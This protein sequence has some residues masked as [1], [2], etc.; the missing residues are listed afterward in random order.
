MALVLDRIYDGVGFDDL[1]NEMLRDLVVSRACCPRS[2]LAT[3]DYLGRYR[4]REV[5]INV[6]YR[7]MDK[8]DKTYQHQRVQQNHC[9][10]YAQDS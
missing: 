5:D 7:F 9:R 4:G 2:K 10:A 8:L 6:I 1:G 3:T